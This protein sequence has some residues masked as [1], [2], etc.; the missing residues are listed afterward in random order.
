[1]NSMRMIA[2]AILVPAGVIGFG[3][4]T[5]LARATWWEGQR[6]IAAVL[7]IVGAVLAPFGLGTFFWGLGRDGRRGD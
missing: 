3:L 7:Q 2:G 6:D 1:M 4:G 5:M